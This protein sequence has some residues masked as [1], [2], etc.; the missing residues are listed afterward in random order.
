[1][2]WLR[3]LPLKLLAGAAAF[4][5]AMLTGFAVINHYYAYYTSWGGVWQDLSN[6][7]PPN[8]IAVPD[9]TRAGEL[10]KVLEEAVRKR[11]AA[12]NGFLMET[13]I[14][15]AKS[16][17]SRT[18]LIYLPPQYFQQKY[19]DKRF[20]ALELLHGT[21]GNPYDYD[22]IMNVV[23]AYKSAMRQKG[24]KPAVLVMPDSNG[25]QANALQCLNVVNGP[26]D[27]TYLAEDVPDLLTA[28]LRV[29]PT[30]KA[31]GVEGFS[32]GGFCAA[33]LALRHPFTYGLAGV[34]SGY[35]VPAKKVRLPEPVDPFAGDEALRLANNPLKMI[36]SWPHDDR[37]PVFWFSA[38]GADQQ[39]M[40]NAE[41]FVDRVRSFQPRVRYH[42]V[43][44]GAHSF[45]VW[46]RSLPRFLRWAVRRLPSATA[47]ERERAVRSFDA[48][49][50]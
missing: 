19:A 12:K 39:D 3:L 45:A 20:P 15:G 8:V 29:L 2:V 33:N 47:P 1:M 4:L 35:F 38:G 43:K 26:Q 7:A 37:L 48:G 40:V 46:R 21:P 34:L 30:G 24:A 31:W 32:E 11:Q 41:A 23:G 44:G 9:L 17:I 36:A 22:R 50:P 28:R 10:E 42:V 14:D 13:P 6:S 18:S 16:K 25:G 49:R 5:P 27:E